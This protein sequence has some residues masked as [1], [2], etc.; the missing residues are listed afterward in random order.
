M[1]KNTAFSGYV[2][3]W[4]PMSKTKFYAVRHGRT[5]GIFNDWMTCSESVHGFKGAVYKSFPDRESAEAYLQIRESQTIDESIPYAYIDG[6][7]KP[8]AG[9]YGYGGFINNDG[10]YYLVQGTGNNPLFVSERNVAGEVIGTIQTIW[11]ALNLGISEL[12]LFYDYAGIEQWAT[13]GWSA[14]S[15]LSRQYRDAMNRIRNRIKIHYVKVKGHTGVEGNE[16]ADIL[17]KEAVG[18]K[19]RKKDV[20]TIGEFKKGIIA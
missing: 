19:L 9:V 4:T 20:L 1:G 5:T 12:N 16:L 14:K 2:E 10:K 8:A 6:S 11:K 13:G 7:F 3:Q 15:D 18:V 17:A